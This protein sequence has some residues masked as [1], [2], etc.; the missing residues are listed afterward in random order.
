VNEE[1]EAA[2]EEEE[3]EEEEH[4]QAERKKKRRMEEEEEEEG[5]TSSPSAASRRSISNTSNQTLKLNTFYII[6]TKYCDFLVTF[7]GSKGEERRKRWHIKR[8]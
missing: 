1:K 8:I 3:E 5:P 2:A 6:R 7:N 4:K